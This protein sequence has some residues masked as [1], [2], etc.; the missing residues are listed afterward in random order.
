MLLEDLAVCLWKKQK[1]FR[2][3]QTTVTLCTS[4]LN[5][6]ENIQHTADLT[7]SQDLTF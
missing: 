3:L 7:V 2:I 4:I 5:M 6:S 1:N